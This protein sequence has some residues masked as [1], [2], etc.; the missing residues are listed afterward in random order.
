MKTAEEKEGIA[1]WMGG[2]RDAVDEMPRPSL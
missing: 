2:I 1:E